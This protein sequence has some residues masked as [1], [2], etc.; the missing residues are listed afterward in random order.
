MFSDNQNYQMSLLPELTALAIIDHQVAFEQCF[1]VKSLKDAEN[2][3]A[4]LAGAAKQV[5]IPTLTSLIKTNLIGPKLSAT[6]EPKLP[7]MTRYNRNGLNPWDDPGFVKAVQTINRPCLLVAGLSVETSLA[8]TALGALARGF[9][10]FVIKDA[11]LGYSE[12]SIA[13][14]FER[15][16]Q[17]GVVP[18]SWR[19][20]ILE[21]S[22]GN[23]DACQLR[24]ILKPKNL[25]RCMDDSLDR[26]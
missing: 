6:L 19:Q 7:K 24:R 10:V 22:Q 5:G 20:V 15:L 13:T 21:W 9:D 2:G 1:D 4:E 12:Q 16:M 8:F 17:A 11:C 14:A 18:V 23:V 26:D 3:V 25:D